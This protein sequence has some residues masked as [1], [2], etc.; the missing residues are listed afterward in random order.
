VAK[1]EEEHAKN[2]AAVNALFAEVDERR[3]AS[4]FQVDAFSNDHNS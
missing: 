3:K 4:E 2:V 1:I